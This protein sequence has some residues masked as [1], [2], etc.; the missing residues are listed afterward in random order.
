MYSLL[1]TARLNGIE[2][3]GRLKDTLDKLPAWPPSRVN[4]LLPLARPAASLSASSP[5]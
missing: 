5:S 3:Y 2:P 1:G 4:E